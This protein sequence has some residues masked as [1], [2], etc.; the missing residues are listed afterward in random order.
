MIT[1]CLSFDDGR[2]DSYST[3]FAILSKYG[4]KASF[5]I[6]TGFVDGTFKQECFGTGRKSVTIDNLLEMNDAGMDISSHGNNHT[7]EMSDYYL[8]VEKLKKWGIN[9]DKY[10]FSVPNSRYNDKELNSF[11]IETKDTLNYVRVGR[12]S[13]CKTFVNKIMFFLYRHFHWYWCFH[14][15]NKYNI[16]YKFDRFKIVS[17][18]VKK[19]TRF[20]DLSRFINSH[21]NDNCFLVIM[22][23]SI[24]EHPSNDWEWCINSFSKLCSFL[25]SDIKNIRVATIEEVVNGLDK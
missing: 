19:Q 14:Y 1:V 7:M 24:V 6:A 11:L 4:L 18:V 25:H 16:I 21:K 23:H 13:K 22:L 5:H 15:F 3:A 10:G 20:K 12:S 9:K 2:I 17:L 8:S